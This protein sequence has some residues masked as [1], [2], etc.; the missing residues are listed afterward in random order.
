MIGKVNLPNVSQYD[1]LGFDMDFTIIRY[2]IPN[3]L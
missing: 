2:N 3:L 1:A